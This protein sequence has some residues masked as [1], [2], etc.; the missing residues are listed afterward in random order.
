MTFALRAALLGLA[1][2]LPLSIAQAQPAA[3]PAEGDATKGATLFR[4]RCAVCHHVDANTAPR[5]GPTLKGV[6]GR[7]AGAVPNFR[8]S[9]PLKASNLTW[10]AA[11]LHRF[12]AAP[13]QVVPGTFMVIGLPSATERADVIAY[14]QTVK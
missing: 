7:K 10:D 9:N 14:L 2:V 13:A 8:Y 4:Q 3:A 5:P 12:L 11:T 1:F 6:A